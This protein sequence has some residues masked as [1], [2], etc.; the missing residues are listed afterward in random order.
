[1][2]V[3]DFW[4][5]NPHQILGVKPECPAHVPVEVD[6]A[7]TI[8][9]WCR[10]VLLHAA[11]NGTAP[12]HK[13]GLRRAQNEHCSDVDTCSMGTCTGSE[14]EGTWI[15]VPMKQCIGGSLGTNP[16]NHTN[17]TT[18]TKLETAVNRFAA[19]S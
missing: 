1:M 10:A 6:D 17:Q 3:P 16:T 9:L 18:I 15:R 19:S 5:E 7:I 14:N 12:H 13:G 11:P 8:N 4:A 2:Y